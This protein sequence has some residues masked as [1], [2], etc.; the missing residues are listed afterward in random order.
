MMHTDDWSFL[1][2]LYA[3]YEVGQDTTITHWLGHE[4]QYKRAGWDNVYLFLS[5]YD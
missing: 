4:T 3:E 2:P 5:D 1:E